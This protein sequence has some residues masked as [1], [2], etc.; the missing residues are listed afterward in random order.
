MPLIIRELLVNPPTWF[1]SLRDLTL[2]YHIFLKDDVLIES[3]DPDPYYLWLKS[4]GGMDFVEEF[5]RPGSE[6]GVRLDIE[7]NFPRTVV[8]DRITPENLH[9]LI[10]KI[11]F[12][13]GLVG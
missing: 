13:R 3:E 8:T 4:R 1:S 12:A 9:W 7:H 5:V 2:Y 10:G 6:N 11:R